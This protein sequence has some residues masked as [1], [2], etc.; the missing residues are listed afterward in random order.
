MIMLATA[1]C[2]L[3]F[4]APHGHAMVLRPSARV[5]MSESDVPP[6]GGV[7]DTLARFRAD[8]QTGKDAADAYMSGFSPQSEDTPPSTGGAIAA[9]LLAALHVE[10]AQFVLVFSGA[11]LFGVGIPAATAPATGVRLHSA[12]LAAVASR[13]PTRL[14]RLP[15]EAW[16][17]RAVRRGLR[18]GGFEYL[19]DQSAQPLAVLVTVVI[20]AR[21]LERTLLVGVAAA[22]LLFALSSLGSGLSERTERAGARL[23]GHA[24]A[25][26]VGF[27]RAEDLVNTN[28]VSAFLIGLTELDARLFALLKASWRTAEALDARMLALVAAARQ[29]AERAVFE[30]QRRAALLV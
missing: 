15:L 7:K 11:W 10:V 1:A 5:L 16:R 4:A 26:W 3:R 23:A 24:R 8:F 20:T 29:A 18:R 19:K 2:A 14:L 12:A 22:P 21:A 17:W 28:L 9:V 27:A 25:A 6:P 30:L 13:H